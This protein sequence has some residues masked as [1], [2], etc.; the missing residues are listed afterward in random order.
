LGPKESEGAISARNISEF[1]FNLRLAKRIEE[2]LELKAESFPQQQHCC[3]RACG[4]KMPASDMPAR[5]R[6]PWM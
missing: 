4:K 2:K 6:F 3:Y 5:N 1:L